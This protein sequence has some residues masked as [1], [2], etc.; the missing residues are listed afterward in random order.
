MTEI[1]Q[2]P[3]GIDVVHGP[4]TY[5]S[6]F[7]GIPLNQQCP[8]VREIH[9]DET[10]PVPPTFNLDGDLAGVRRITLDP[11]PDSDSRL[12]TAGVLHIPRSLLDAAKNSGSIDDL[13]R[14]IE[15]NAK[16]D[17]DGPVIPP[18]IVI[19]D[20]IPE[21]GAAASEPHPFFSYG[22]PTCEH[23]GKQSNDP[24]HPIPDDD[25]DARYEL[26]VA[27]LDHWASWFRNVDADLIR[28]DGLDEDDLSEL[29]TLLAWAANQINRPTEPPDAEPGLEEVIDAMI[30]AVVTAADRAR[31]ILDRV[32]ERLGDRP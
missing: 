9:P 29:S 8:G 14:L 28:D 3:R 13:V 21:E 5:T 27:R 30:D 22:T 4:H 26:N 23:C 12:A 25:D 31:S 7:L 19:D 2:Q 20:D 18:R 16:W 6:S 32:A 24:I 10:I 17:A 1:P 15:T 11:R